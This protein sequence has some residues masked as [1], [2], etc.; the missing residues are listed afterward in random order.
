MPPDLWS[1]ALDL[2]AR[3]GVENTCLRLQEQGA[4]VCLLLAAAWLGRRGVR[5]DPV[6]AEQLQGI[7]G[8]WQRDV[9]EPLRRLRQAWREAAGTDTGLRELRD[10]VKRLELDAER[11]LLARLEEIAAPWPEADGQDWSWLD[12]LAGTARDDRDALQSLRAAAIEA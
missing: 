4:D 7:A 1:F 8:P 2:Y 5:Y 9:V 10:G 3:P 6:C 11:R 12:V